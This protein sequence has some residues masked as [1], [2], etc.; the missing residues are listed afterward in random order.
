MSTLVSLPKSPRPTTAYDPSHPFGDARFRAAL[1]RALAR[2]LPEGDAEDLVQ[3]ALAEAVAA[4]KENED[5]VLLRRWV[6]AVARNK[7]I[8][9][10]RKRRE[11]LGNVGD[12][13]DENAKIAD[14][15]AKVADDDDIL[16]WAANEMPSG[17]GAEETLE[18][19]LR[20][21]DGESLESIA[22]ES[23]LPATRVR[24]RVSRL[25]EHFRRRWSLY[26][27]ALA[28]LGIAAALGRQFLF[29]PVRPEPIAKDVPSSFAPKG[30]E[31]TPQELAQDFRRRAFTE[32]SAGAARACIDLLD[33]ARALDPDGDDAKDV[34]QARAAAMDVLSPPLPRPPEPKPPTLDGGS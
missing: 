1:V 4:G 24:K 12:A 19:M 5:P 23:R 7:M 27:A 18:W 2:R 21:A 29:H 10:F 22:K 14:E 25:R 31:R 26:V 13:A 34:Q 8:D 16:R 17:D 6:A 11:L 15:N 20:E 32:C 9:H 33:E 3:S 28:A 30:P